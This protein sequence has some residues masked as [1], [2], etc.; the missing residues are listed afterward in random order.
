MTTLERSIIIKG[1]RAEI[2][3]VT[4]DGN[5][6]S[7]WYAGI[8]ESKADQR[9]PEVGGGVDTVYKAA[10]ISFKVKITSVEFKRG[11]GISL[12]MDGM[13]TG[14][15]RWIYND[16][17][18][19]TQVTARLDYEMP[20]GGIGKAVNKLIVEKMNADNL[21]KSLNNL[22]KIVEGS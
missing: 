15:N 3:A 19:G 9:Y 7:E 8:Q 14:T 22:K 11:E 17:E 6:L 21:E 20:G 1:S 10:G 18:G 2:D 13:I 16:V 12:Q 5:R 4:L